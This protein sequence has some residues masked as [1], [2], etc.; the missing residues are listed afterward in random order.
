MGELY[1]VLMRRKELMMYGR[2]YTL[3]ECFKWI[4]KGKVNNVYLQF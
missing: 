2:N 4:F 3:S 1:L